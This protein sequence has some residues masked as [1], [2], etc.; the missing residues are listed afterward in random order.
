MATKTKTDR[1][2]VDRKAL[3]YG[4]GTVI[5]AAPTRSSLP[6]LSGV[7]LRR[8][9]GR[10]RLTTTDLELW[11]DHRIDAE[12][13]KKFDVV[14]NARLFRKVLTAAMGDV[15][16]ER[17]DSGLA[18]GWG[19]TTVTLDVLPTDE[20][21]GDRVVEGKVL[22]F[23]AK[24]VELIRKIAN[25]A[26]LGDYRPILCGLRFSNDK[27]MPGVAGTDSYRLGVAKLSTKVP[28]DF[29][30][31]AAVARHLP[32]RLLDTE[33]ID[34]VLDER[35]V[36]FKFG[37][38]TIQS[39][40]IQGEFPDIGKFAPKTSPCNLTFNRQELIRAA[41]NAA[42]LTAG[43]VPVRLKFDLATM[44]AAVTLTAQTFGTVD[45]SVDFRS[46]ADLP[47]ETCAFNAVYLAQML[48][49]LTCEDVT[50]EMSSPLKPVLVRDE[51]LT[52][53]LMPVRVS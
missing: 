49:A 39:V 3:L 35:H 32:M 22:R 36:Q 45:T 18:V 46:S 27:P 40:L 52:M 7:R 29:L 34:V 17:T 15:W 38:T 13:P 20:Y 48:E 10:L 16:I 8:D 2:V 23:T 9:R 4:L 24:D 47:A 14:V 33:T 50:L 12:V 51:D 26:C 21:P 6:V 31:P 43:V 5:P 30:M 41:R 37:D 42:M 44:T 25:F 53:L 19:R 1:L 28:R 11:I